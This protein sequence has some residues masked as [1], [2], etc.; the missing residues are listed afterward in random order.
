[1]QDIEQ[2]IA[3]LERKL[4]LKKAY[5]AVQ[6]TFGKGYKAFPDD[7]RAEVEK[8]LLDAAKSNA[9]DSEEVTPASLNLTLSNEEIMALK[10]IA[11]SVLEKSTAPKKVEEVVVLTETPQG[12]QIAPPKSI[13]KTPTSGVLLL[14][15]SLSSSQRH[16]V[17]SGSTVQILET[18]DDKYYV[19]DSKHNRFWIPQEDIELLA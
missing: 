4:L 17:D 6:V 10:H 8:T 1:M 5:L 13:P 14:L 2:Q 18:R 15:D 16:K 19:Q 7:V 11:R 3:D 9:E 12:H